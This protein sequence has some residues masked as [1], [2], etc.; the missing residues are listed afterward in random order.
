MTSVGWHQAK[1]LLM[2]AYK[3][4]IAFENSNS[5]DYVTE[6][7]FGALAEGTVPS[8]ERKREREREEEKNAVK[9]ICTEDNEK[10][11]NSLIG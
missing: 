10:K 2:R 11:P 3:F 5:P 9:E 1:R 6:K 4:A 8:K 7:L